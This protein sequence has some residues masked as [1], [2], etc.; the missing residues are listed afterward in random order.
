M[1]ARDQTLIR[2]RDLAAELQINIST[3]C[4]MTAKRKDLKAAKF[5]RDRYL[6]QRL[7]DCGILPKLEECEVALG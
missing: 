6:V 1:I 4:R 5:A 7:R 2:S 3:L